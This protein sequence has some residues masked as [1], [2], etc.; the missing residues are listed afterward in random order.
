[1]CDSWDLALQVHQKSPVEQ[2]R[3][4]VVPADEPFPSRRGLGVLAEVPVVGQRPPVDPVTD[5]I[6]P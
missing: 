6:C 3:H 5:P 2:R 1:M 4:A